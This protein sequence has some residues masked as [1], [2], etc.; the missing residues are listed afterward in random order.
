MQEGIPRLLNGEFGLF[1]LEGSDGKKDHCVAI[2]NGFIFDSN[3]PRAM[4]LS[5]SAL[6]LCCS[7]DDRRSTFVRVVRHCIFSGFKKNL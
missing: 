2:Y 5:Q 4:E 1:S 6:D 7:S 3:V